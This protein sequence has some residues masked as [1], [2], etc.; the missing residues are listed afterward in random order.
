MSVNAPLT[1]KYVFNEKSKRAG[2]QIL[3]NEFGGILGNFSGATDF[4]C[5][6]ENC[7]YENIDSQIGT[8]ELSS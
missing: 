7:T 8:A 6:I 1:S 2:E 3:T 5:V 4:S